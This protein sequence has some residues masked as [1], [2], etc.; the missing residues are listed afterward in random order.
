M[1][2]QVS[3]QIVTELFQR[4]TKN[5]LLLLEPLDRDVAQYLFHPDHFNE[6]YQ[7]GMET[8][9][10][11]KA[12]KIIYTGTV[13]RVD[14]NTVYLTLWDTKTNQAIDASCLKD[15]FYENGIKDLI[16]GMT[17]KYEIINYKGRPFPRI[18][19]LKVEPSEKELTEAESELEDIYADF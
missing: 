17:I 12:Q 15:T 2:K 10:A 6:E 16:D 18:R 4:M 8:F 5:A 9:L 7:F 14:G 13:N 19:P 11:R 1:K 3:E